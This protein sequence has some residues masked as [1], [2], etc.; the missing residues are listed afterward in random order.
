V[1]WYLGNEQWWRPLL[2]RQGVGERLGVQG[3]K[4]GSH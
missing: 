4:Q 1:R 3:N 2:A